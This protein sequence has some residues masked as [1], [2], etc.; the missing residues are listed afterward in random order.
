[1]V[2]QP[3]GA[4]LAKVGLIFGNLWWMYGGYAWLTNAVPPRDRS[5][6]SL[7]LV[8]M[9]AFLVAALA[10]PRAFS[11]DGVVFGVAYLV[12]NLVH[13]G[14]FMRSSQEGAVRAML[15]LGPTNA[16]LAVIVLLAGTI[17]GW[18][19]WALWTAAFVLH[20]ASPA[21]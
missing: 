7:M 11:T 12:V 14:L 2:A 15:R 19:R 6:R 10:I 18:P 17:G 20:W 9:G 3:T 1:L 8:G 13:A 4:G 5:R 21:F 16:S